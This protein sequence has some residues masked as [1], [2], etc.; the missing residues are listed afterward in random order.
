[1]FLDSVAGE[2]KHVVDLLI[3]SAERLLWEAKGQR[4]ARLLSPVRRN[5]HGELTTEAEEVTIFF[6]GHKG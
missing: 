6:S 5:G 1:M 4:F 3:A 2:H